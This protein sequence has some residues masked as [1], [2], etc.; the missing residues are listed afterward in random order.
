[1]AES[2]RGLPANPYN[3]HAWIT[4]EPEIGAGTWI[5][6]FTVVDGSGGLRIGAGCDLSCGV[7]IY[8]HNT[9]RRCVTGQRYPQVDRAPVWIGDHVFFG[10]NAVVLMG[11]T[12]GDSAVIGAG[13]VVTHDVPASTAVAGVPARPIGTVRDDGTIDYGGS[14]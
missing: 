5:G 3:A 12:I 14:A 9:V 4:G 6:A 13:A 11:V 1:M 8:T 7:Q 10:A 2:A